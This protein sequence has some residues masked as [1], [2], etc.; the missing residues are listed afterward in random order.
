L[1][2]LCAQQL[3]FF[4]QSRILGLQFG[5]ALGIFGGN[6]QATHAHGQSQGEN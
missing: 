2:L 4:A 1:A 6:R 3:K 5:Q